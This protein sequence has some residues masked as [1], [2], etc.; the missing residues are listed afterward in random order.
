MSVLRKNKGI[1]NVDDYSKNSSVNNSL[2]PKIFKE[3]EEDDTPKLTRR[4]SR[5][6]TTSFAEI[7]L[8]KPP[9]LL[10]DKYASNNNISGLYLDEE[11]ENNYITTRR[12]KVDSKY[13]PVPTPRGKDDPFY[14]FTERT[15]KEILEDD[16]REKMPYYKTYREDKSRIIKAINIKRNKYYPRLYKYS[17]RDHKFNEIVKFKEDITIDNYNRQV[18]RY[19]N[20]IELTTKSQKCYFLCK[21]DIFNLYMHISYAL[22]TVLFDYYYN[23]LKLIILNVSSLIIF[24]YSPDLITVHP[25]LRYFFLVYFSVDI[26][27][28]MWTLGFNLAERNYFSSTWNLFDLFF[29]IGAWL[30]FSFGKNNLFNIL[31]YR[32]LCWD[33]S[34][35]PFSLLQATQQQTF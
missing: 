15:K 24:F 34:S 3:E 11:E 26:F 9:K 33:S 19:N 32:L 4:K 23:L 16:Y 1:Y 29:V 5:L 13:T 27:M 25:F 28:K 17:L 18:A 7:S 12:E 20:G 21:K 35:L 14:D 6:K 10:N 2:L 8:K 22:N 30:E 31:I